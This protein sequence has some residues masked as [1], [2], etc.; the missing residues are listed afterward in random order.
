MK[1]SEAKGIRAILDTVIDGIP[2]TNEAEFNAAAE[3]VN[4]NA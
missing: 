3:K 1:R 4:V 2:A